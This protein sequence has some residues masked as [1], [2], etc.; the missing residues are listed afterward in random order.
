MKPSIVHHSHSDQEAPTN[1]EASIHHNSP[2]IKMFKP[3]KVVH[4]IHGCY[5]NC[6]LDIVTAMWAAGPRFLGILGQAFL[7]PSE[8]IKLP[9]RPDTS[10]CCRVSKGSLPSRLPSWLPSYLLRS[11]Q[12]KRI[13][14]SWLA[15][16]Q[17]RWLVL[18]DRRLAWF[19]GAFAA[20]HL[21]QTAL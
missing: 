11:G 7:K 10:N 4:P 6:Y 15:S 14:A 8:K 12:V 18:K 9:E 1:H 3:E 5:N 16:W 21:R 20:L 2:S 17:W 13:S 19:D